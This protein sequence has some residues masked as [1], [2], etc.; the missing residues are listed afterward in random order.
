MI[1]RD[2]VI[3][4]VKSRYTKVVSRT[5][6]QAVSGAKLYATRLSMFRKAATCLKNLDRLN[7]WTRLEHCVSNR[8]GNLMVD[9]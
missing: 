3:L 7:G 8:I 1:E 4:A 6:N 9:Y 2:G 5:K